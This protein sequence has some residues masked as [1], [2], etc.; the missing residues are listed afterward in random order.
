[1]K[2]PF[3]APIAILSGA[4]LFLLIL[5][6]SRFI[7]SQDGLCDGVIS[8]FQCQ[9]EI[10][11]FWGQYTPFF[12]VPSEIRAKIPKECELKSVQILSRHGA[13]FPTFD[14]TV[15]YATL[16]QRIQKDVK[17]FKGKYAFLKD[18]RYQLGSDDLTAFGQQELVNSG[19]KF[20]ERYRSLT[21]KGVPFIRSSDEGRVVMSAVNFTR[22]FHDARVK[23][24]GQDPSD[25]Y[26][27]RIVKISEDDGMNNTLNHGLCSAFEDGKFSEIG[28][29]MEDKRRD[30]F[31]PKIKKRLNKHLDGADLSDKDVISLMEMCPFD[32]VASPNG[33]VSPFCALFSTEEF[34]EYDY[35]QSVSKYY[36]HG[37]GNLL[38]PT[39]GVGYVNEIIARLTS[40]PVHDHTSVNQTLDSDP[41]TFPLGSQDNVFADFSHD[42]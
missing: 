42:K 1:M 11:H 32:T 25:G 37:N 41:R 40:E 24:R 19:I 23:D 4:A 26:P 33:T 13:R 22:G 10:S 15:E 21:S 2:W 9:P 30:R 6:R 31:V 28:D 38:G 14:H 17:Q 29:D 39:Q 20:Y 34:H 5:V 27:Y 7:V 3:A 8:G 12:S 35:L 16:I 36:G 18:Y